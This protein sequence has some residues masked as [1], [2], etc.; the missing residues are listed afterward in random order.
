MS[1][2]ISTS[3]SP[4]ASP[5]S[6]GSQSP[7]AASSPNP[8]PRPLRH[9]R[10]LARR[11]RPSLLALPR[12]RRRKL[13]LLRTP[14]PPARLLEHFRHQPAR[15]SAAEKSIRRMPPELFRGSVNASHISHN[16]RSY[17]PADSSR[18]HGKYFRNSCRLWHFSCP[19]FRADCNGYLGRAHDHLTARWRRSARLKSTRSSRSTASS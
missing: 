11:P 6:A 9:R 2:P 16:S 1:I 18:R 19:V 15:R 13:P 5:N 3:K 4:A 7:C 10:P 17:Q 12:N 8:R 14:L